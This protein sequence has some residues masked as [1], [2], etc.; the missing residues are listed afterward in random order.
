MATRFD[1]RNCNAQCRKCNRFDE[2]NNIGYT[3][4]LIAKYGDKVIDELYIKKYIISK[5]SKA[6]FEILIDHYKNEVKKL[7]DAKT[8]K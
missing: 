8:P 6:E 3:K 2:G 4:G 7:K 5:M 1:E